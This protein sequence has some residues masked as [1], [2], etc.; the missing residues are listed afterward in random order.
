MKTVMNS[1]VLRGAPGEIM[2]I[3]RK[4]RTQGLIDGKDFS[5]KLKDATSWE[6]WCKESKWIDYLSKQQMFLTLIH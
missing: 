3:V 5:F 2:P 6:F 4:L 1:I